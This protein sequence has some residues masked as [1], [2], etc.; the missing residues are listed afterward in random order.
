MVSSELEGEV[1]GLI[2]KPGRFEARFKQ[3]ANLPILERPDNKV[4]PVT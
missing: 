4:L 3:S 1:S 2:G